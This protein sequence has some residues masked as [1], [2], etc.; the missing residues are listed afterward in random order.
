MKQAFLENPDL[1]RRVK[2]AVFTTNDRDPPP[3]CPTIGEE[4]GLFHQVE[5]VRMVLKLAAPLDLPAD[6]EFPVLKRISL[7]GDPFFG[8]V[9]DKPHLES[10]MSLLDK[11][12]QSLDKLWLEDLCIYRPEMP[13]NNITKL[14]VSQILIPRQILETVFATSFPKLQTLVWDRCGVVPDNQPQ[15]RPTVQLSNTIF[16]AI[17]PLKQT[18]I[19][20]HVKLHSVIFEEARHNLPLMSSLKTLRMDGTWAPV[21][22]ED[23]DA[24]ED[25]WWVDDDAIELGKQHAVRQ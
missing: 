1:A 24:W 11:A 21:T 10:V 12:S 20:L 7:V 13:C 9:Y 17:L 16:K 5:D 15:S 23:D 25:E 4:L 14:H 19:H 3:G 22:E 18:L 8:P 6:A 2:R